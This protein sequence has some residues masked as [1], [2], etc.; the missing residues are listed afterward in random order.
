MLQEPDMMYKTRDEQGQLLQQVL[1]AN[2]TDA[3]EEKIPGEGLRPV[4]VQNER[5]VLLV[6]LIVFIIVKN[7]ERFS[8][9]CIGLLIYKF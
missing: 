8:S 9:I 7:D 3:D 4:S 5:N 6:I 2:D 1:S